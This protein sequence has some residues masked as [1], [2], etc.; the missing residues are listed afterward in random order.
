M[1]DLIEK[2]PAPDEIQV[3]A[4]DGVTEPGLVFG[5]PMED[6]GFEMVEATAGFAAGLAIGAVVAGPIGAA[7]GG[8][9]GAA[10]GFVAGEALER[11]AGRAATTTDATDEESPDAI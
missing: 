10:G 3:H 2:V 5:R 11:A 1:T 9:A 8:L 4:R 6:R 7:V